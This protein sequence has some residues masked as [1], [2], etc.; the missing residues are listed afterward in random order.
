MVGDTAVNATTD[1]LLAFIYNRDTIIADRGEGLYALGDPDDL[2]RRD[3][4]I[5]WF[6]A[7]QAP[8]DQA[9]TFTLVNVHTEHRHALQ[10]LNVL[11]SVFYEVRHDWRDE[12]DVIMLGCFQRPE[13]KLA[14]LAK[15]RGLVPAVR[16]TPTS[17]RG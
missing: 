4:L 17:V 8:E 2:L 6:R 11:D 10:E 14:G 1:Q 7:K 16:G 5:G 3:P 9:F 12:D 15:L 13:T